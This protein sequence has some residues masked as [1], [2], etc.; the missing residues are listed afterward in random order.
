[1]YLREHH[2]TNFAQVSPYNLWT[3]RAL[4]FFSVTF[5]SITFIW[6]V[7]LLVSIFVSPPYL[8]TRGSGFFDFSYTTLTAG[9]LLTSLLFFTAPSLAIRI[10]ISIIAG[11]LLVNVI[12]IAS[13]G[14]IR[15]EESAPGIASVVWAT[16]MAAY[17]VLTDRVVAWGKREEE[18]RPEGMAC[19]P[20]RDYHPGHLRSHRRPD[21][22]HAHPPKP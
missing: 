11:L 4:R 2:P 6:W 12:I 9:L 3:V 21:D 8:H 5:L 14:R 15:T 20:Y 16:I 22:C 10:T 17:C 18:E 1:M 13:V 19:H 7:L